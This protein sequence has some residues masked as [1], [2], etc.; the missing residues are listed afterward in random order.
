MFQVHLCQFSDFCNTQC[1]LYSG[2]KFCAKINSNSKDWYI[3]R[4]VMINPCPKLQFVFE[5][6]Q[7]VCEIASKHFCILA[8]FHFKL[9][10]EY[11]KN[12]T[13]RSMFQGHLCQFSDFCNTQCGLNSIHLSKFVHPCQASTSKWTM[14]IEKIKNIRVKSFFQVH[15]C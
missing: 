14:K 10:N 4:K 5:I 6:L 11:V 9:E 12:N 1:G 7:R 3:V 15:L 13:V 2:C 8:G